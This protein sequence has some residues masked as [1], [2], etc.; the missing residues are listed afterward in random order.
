MGKHKNL[1]GERFGKLVVRAQASP[2]GGEKGGRKSW[3]CDCDCGNTAII[4]TQS[5]I[6][7]RSTSC[8]CAARETAALPPANRK[9]DLSGERF[10]K[11]TVLRRYIQDYYEIPAWLCR[12][13]CGIEVAY[14]ASVL[15]AGRAKSCG[16]CDG[17][18]EDLIV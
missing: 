8:G 3:L 14:P 18:L 5:L 16:V 15:R 2:I 4:E 6:M 7:C 9:K 13:D 11:L 17:T 1:V 10:G 12:C